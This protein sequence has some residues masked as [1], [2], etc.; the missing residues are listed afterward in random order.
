M[1]RSINTSTTNVAIAGDERLYIITR[2]DLTT[3]YQIPQTIHA[4][5][6]FATEFPIEYAEWHKNSNTLV[7]LS[8]ATEQDLH[9][10]IE[11]LKAKGFRFT[12]FREPD[13]DNAITSICLV[14]GAGIR[15]ACSG[16]P[17]AGKTVKPVS[18]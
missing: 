13:I 15:K 7:V 11:K 5:M 9:R 18:L 12:I 10:L 3:Q 1:H 16:I 14:P 2:S 8:V 4:A 6:D 17:L